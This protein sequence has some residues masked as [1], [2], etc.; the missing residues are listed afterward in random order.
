VTWG[1]DFTSR[2]RTDLVGLESDVHD[3][4]TETLLDWARNGPPRERG[5]TMQGIEFYEATVA[6]RYLLAYSIDD[7]R[8]T[9]VVLWI[10]QKPGVPP[11]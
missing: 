4:I 10:R 5:R 2:V 8:R 1:V 11:R 9:F 3:A 7:A 6:E